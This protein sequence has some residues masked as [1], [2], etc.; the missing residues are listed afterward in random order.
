MDKD[1][2]PTPTADS[3]LHNSPEKEDMHQV[4]RGV[5]LKSSTNEMGMS[6]CKLIRKGNCYLNSIEDQK[7]MVITIS[8]MRIQSGILE[9]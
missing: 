6:N 9:F 4:A 5:V 1:L 3:L 2:D 7:I 8:P